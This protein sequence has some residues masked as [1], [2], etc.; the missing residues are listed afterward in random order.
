MS[1]NNT[2]RTIESRRFRAGVTVVLLAVIVFGSP[3]VAAESDPV[4]AEPGPVGAESDPLGGSIEVDNPDD[5]GDCF[6]IDVISIEGLIRTQRSVVE[7]ELLVEEGDVATRE[8]VEESIQRLRN[9]GVF[10]SVDYDL[11]DERIGAYDEETGVDGELEGR[12]LRVSVDER[13]TISPSFRFGHGGDTLHLRLG[14]QDANIRGTFLQ[15]GVSYSRLG[16]ANSFSIWF[17]DPRFQDERQSVTL[18][19]SLNNRLFTLYD[20]GGDVDGGYLRTRRH[21]SAAFESEWRRWFRTG[22]HASFSADTFSYDMVSDDRRIAQQLRGGVYDPMQTLRVG[23]S[24]RI[25]RIDHYRYRRAGTT[26]GVGVDQ[27]FHFG[28][29]EPVSRSFEANLRH[30]AEMPFDTQIANRSSIGFRNVEPSH[31]QFFAGGLDVVRGTFNNR[32]RGRHRW[33]NNLELRVPSYR[34]NWVIFEHVAFL[35]TVGVAD[36]VTDVFGLTA[37]TTGIGL[38]VISRDFYSMII[39]A[40]YAFPV[41]G[42][43]G[44]GLS[45]GVGQFF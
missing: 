3:P 17:R 32:F 21:A 5:C 30:Y 15:G 35:D 34:N 28:D 31:M 6:R 9:T 37:A 18:R 7:R 43:D 16:D 26:L 27:N 40:D 20:A 23:V 36:E 2:A 12:L 33:Y 22:M 42:A 38:R 10:R 13:Y 19:A 45:F 39:R 44:P 41:M 25:G 11:T 1:S 29:I 4:G 14:L 8:H 24:G